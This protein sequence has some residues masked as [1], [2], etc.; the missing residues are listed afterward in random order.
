MLSDITSIPNSTME[1]S[2]AFHRRGSSST[3]PDKAR[4]PIA[5]A[6][7]LSRAPTSSV[8]YYDGPSVLN[9]IKKSN[10]RVSTSRGYSLAAAIRERA[11][12]SNTLASAG[13][14]WAS[15]QSL[16]DLNSPT[17]GAFQNSTERGGILD[18][19]RSSPTSH[20]FGAPSHNSSSTSLQH[21]YE[22]MNPRLPSQQQQQQQTDLLQRFPTIN[23][24]FAATKSSVQTD[25]SEES[26]SASVHPS[27]HSSSSG[28]QA[29]EISLLREPSG[30]LT[31]VPVPAFSSLSDL[32]SFNIQ[33]VPPQYGT[34][35]C[36]VRRVRR[37]ILFASNPVYLVTLEDQPLNPGK[38]L[39]AARKRTSQSTSNY[40]ISMEENDVSRTS[41]TYLGKLRSNFLGTEFTVYDDGESPEKVAK[42]A[43]LPLRS[44]LGVVIYAPNVIGARGPRKMKVAIP[45]VYKSKSKDDEKD[46]YKRVLF[47]P[48][49]VTTIAT[50]QMQ[51][52]TS[53][54][55]QVHSGHTQDMVLLVNNPPKWNEAAG[56]YVLNFNGR[57]TM[58]SVKNFQLVQPE[59]HSNVMLQFGKTGSDTYSMDFK[60]PLSPFQAFSIV[61]SSLDPKLACE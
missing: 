52:D 38:V 8:Q 31:E 10:L 40:V 37:G 14:T 57:V 16:S 18:S 47:Q 58:P 30:N 13:S 5:S 60:Y 32:R 41:T 9:D 35:H 27:N 19:N 21:R 54:S 50:S 39:M 17:N 25:S 42:N 33:V 6:H 23:E 29:S 45:K 61:L 22:S 24:A 26:R 53:M 11:A 56:A 2:S 28:K 46:I 59:N 49:Y 12:K 4:P 51:V 44:E 36:S 3:Q 15:H 55:G 1:S 43:A 7:R 20:L 48:T 34:I